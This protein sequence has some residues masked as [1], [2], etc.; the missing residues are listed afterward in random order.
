MGA[1][2]E[3]EII[4]DKLIY[5]P[6]SGEFTW[7][8]GG[9]SN[10]LAGKSAGCKRA[11]G[12]KIIR[13]GSKLMFAHR[14]AVVLMTGKPIE[15]GKVVDHIN[16]DP[17]DNRWP[18]IRVCLQKENTS[19]RRAPKGKKSSLF[20]GV[21]WF[22]ARKKWV[23]RVTDHYQTHYAGYYDD[24]REAALAYNK[25]ALELFGPFAKLN[26]VC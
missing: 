20:K 25:K 23:V 16:G 13:V 19:N 11:D 22:S 3:T 10:R 8:H 7:R 17:S 9:S 26:E 18:N 24:E 1:T 21:C 12:Y 2:S 6:A 5:D 15:P 4:Q 14:I